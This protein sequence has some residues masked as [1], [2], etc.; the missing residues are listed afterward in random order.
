MTVSV[1]YQAE[2]R[3]PEVVD[4]A[5]SP[6]QASYLAY[7]YAMAFGCLPGQHR[8]G[9]D[10]VWAGRRDEKPQCNGRNSFRF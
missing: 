2:G 8:H 6:G 4:R 9:K 7:E 10:C 3:K 5:S 1:W